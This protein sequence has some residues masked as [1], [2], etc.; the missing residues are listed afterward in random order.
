MF[1]RPRLSKRRPVIGTTFG[2]ATTLGRRARLLTLTSALVLA[3]VLAGSPA[4]RAAS[5]FIKASPNPVTLPLGNA[6]PRPLVLGAT[7]VVGSKHLFHME[8]DRAICGLNTAGRAN[9]MA[10]LA[11]GQIPVGWVDSHNG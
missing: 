5:A 7:S 10:N 4:V 6:T 11:A 1:L 3:G 9:P 8:Q 2:R